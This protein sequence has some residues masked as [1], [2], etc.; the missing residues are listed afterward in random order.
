MTLVAG[1]VALA[2]A[3]RASSASTS[4]PRPRCTKRRCARGRVA[5][6]YIGAAAIS[7]YRPE[8]GP[9]Q[10]I[11]KQ[12]DTLALDLVKCPDV[13]AAVAALPERPFTVG[14]AA[15]T[16]QLEAYALEK[17]QHEE[18]GHDRRQPGG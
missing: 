1:P 15:E 7:D 18:P 11:K 9:A 4:R 6:I 12:A 14:F 2:D 8:H 5:D 16:E 3:A 13:L 10:K 17:L